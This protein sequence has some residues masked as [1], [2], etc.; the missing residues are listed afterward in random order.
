M[1]GG[2]FATLSEVINQIVTVER[3]RRQVLT[4]RGKAD[5]DEAA[6]SVAESIYA[7][8]SA[9]AIKTVEKQPAALEALTGIHAIHA[10]AE[11]LCLK[12][13]GGEDGPLWRL[14]KRISDA[15]DNRAL[16]MKAEKGKLDKLYG[17]YSDKE[18]AG[19]PKEKFIIKSLNSEVIT[20]EN[21][22]AVALNMGNEI[23]HSRLPEAALPSGAA[24][25][26]QALEEILS[27]MT[28]QDCAFVNAAWAYLESFKEESFALEERING[29]K[30]EAVEAKPFMLRLR[31]GKTVYLRGGYYPI[32]YDAKKGSRAQSLSERD[33][34]T[35][36]FGSGFGGSAQTKQNHLR[37]RN[38]YGPG[39]PLLYKLSVIDDHV[40]SVVNDLTMREAA[41]DAAKIL[42]H[43][44]VKS[45]VESV[46]GVRGYD[47]LMSWLRDAA[48]ERRKVTERRNEYA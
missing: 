27:H 40:S 19:L 44:A 8:R 41:M 37:Q 39:A 20:R 21:M 7:H 38:K 45:S 1:S 5:L 48:R 16:R 24:L 46:A 26:Q 30:P 18:R 31:D 14:Y 4:A 34:K 13:D 32:A 25:N 35:D 3:N 23:N 33:I 15:E 36:L 47:L 29:L 10:K 12:L 22:L 6:D 11:A 42:R 43:K 28:E 17:L 2:E 9:Q